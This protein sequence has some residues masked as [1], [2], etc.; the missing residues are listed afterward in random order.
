MQ[1]IPFVIGY[2]PTCFPSS[3]GVSTV[4]IKNCY[5]IIDNGNFK[6]EWGSV[7]N[8]FM[9][10]WLVCKQAIQF[11]KKS[12]L[13]KRVVPAIRWFQVQHWPWTRFPC[14]LLFQK[15]VGCNC[16]SDKIHCE[17]TSSKKKEKK[18]VHDEKNHLHLPSCFNLKFSSSKRSP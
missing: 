7:D 5:N 9:S 17:H 12:I 6:I 3:Q 16:D 1:V 14:L 8:G 13:L 18:A 15:S 4:Q 10:E 11:L 2:L